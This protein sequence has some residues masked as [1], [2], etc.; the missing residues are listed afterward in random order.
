MSHRIQITKEFYKAFATGDRSF[1]EEHLTDDF[2]FSAPP[3][4]HLDRA[5]YFTRCWPGAGKGQAFEFIRL[6]ESGDEVIV[7]YELKHPNGTQGRNTEILT[8]EGDR[9]SRAEVYFGWNID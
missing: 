2:T 1:V 5:G 8:F 7:T 9:V 4:P 3:D 6:I